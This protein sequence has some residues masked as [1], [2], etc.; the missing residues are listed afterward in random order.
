MDKKHPHYDFKK[1]FETA[2]KEP[3]VILHTSGTTG[4]PKPIVWSHEYVVNYVKERRLS[5]PEGYEST[6]M[7][8]L[9]GKVIISFPP[10]H[11]CY[12]TPIIDG[13]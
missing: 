1:V 13:C 4:F 8:L 5:P 3:V 6:D 9:G 10:A 7:L 11:V 12:S 2:K